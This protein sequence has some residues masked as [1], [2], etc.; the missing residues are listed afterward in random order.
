MHAHR[1]ARPGA[2]SLRPPPGLARSERCGQSAADSKHIRGTVQ[3]PAAMSGTSAR[4]LSERSRVTS[5]RST[6][7]SHPVVIRLCLHPPFSGGTGAGGESVLAQA[8]GRVL[9]QCGQ[10]RRAGG[11]GAEQVSRTGGRGTRGVS[12]PA[13]PAPAP[14]R[15]HPASW[16]GCGRAVVCGLGLRGD[17]CTLHDISLAGNGFMSASGFGHESRRAS[18]RR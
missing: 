1:A 7:S 17:G 4:P 2:A 6:R 18:G 9:G 11:R 3:P 13:S 15:R 10:G 12:R 5:P 14:S 8:S 16:C